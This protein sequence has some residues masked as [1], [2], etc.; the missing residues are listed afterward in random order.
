LKGTLNKS[1]FDYIISVVQKAGDMAREI[2]RGALS[3]TRKPDLS[4]VTDADIA[5]QEMLLDALKNRFPDMGFIHEEEF[6]GFDRSP[7]HDEL[8][9]VIDPIDGTAMF[10]MRLPVWCVSVGIFRGYEPLY[11]FV[12]APAAEMFFYNDDDSAYLN[13]EP[14]SADTEAAVM[15]NETNIFAATEIHGVIEIRFPGKVRN[16]GSTAL[17]C[18]L[19]G[20]NKR[21]RSLAFI[22]K[23]MIWDWAGALSVIL[24]AGSKV[25]YFDGTP[26]D[27]KEVFEGGCAFKNFLVAY[28]A[29]DFMKIAGYFHAISGN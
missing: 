11:G 22:G 7:A 12:Y 28:N 15:D 2:Q 9:A 19:L 16:L 13:G 14:V 26:V 3:I 25:N 23:S 21:N 4:I 5:V 27:F 20:D 10:S 18:A 29:P 24:K 17:H 8:T 6:A 1:D